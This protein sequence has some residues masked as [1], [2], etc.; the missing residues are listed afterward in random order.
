MQIAEASQAGSKFLVFGGFG[1]GKTHFASTL[2]QPIYVFDSDKG[3]V[4]IANRL[5]NE[6]LDPSKVKIDF[7]K[8]WDGPYL[9]KKKSTFVQSLMSTINPAPNAYLMWE[10][11]LGEFIEQAQAGTFPYRTVIYDSLT[12]I[13][14]IF[15]NYIM[16]VNGDQGRMFGV[17]NLNDMGNF[18]RKMPELLGM[19]HMLADFGVHTVTTAHVQLKENIR[20][21]KKDPKDKE[22][23]DQLEYMGTY[24]LPAIIGKDLPFGIGLHFDE[25]Y[26]AFIERHGQQ[27]SYK[28]ETKG[29]KDLLC[30]SRNSL[31]PTFVSQDWGA[32]SKILGIK[33]RSV[34]SAP[35]TGSSISGSTATTRRTA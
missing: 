29:D 9:N 35:A 3:A 19:M 2:P 4:T 22:A 27:V 30:K 33:D 12:T 11:K 16:H 7:D 17:A 15:M 26:Y 24:R 23:K 21:L 5:R 18:I 32:I 31:M 28:F 20:G 10:D 14:I 1:T 8:Y 6:G 13:S 34:S 25:V